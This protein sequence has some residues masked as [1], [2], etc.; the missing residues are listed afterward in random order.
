VLTKCKSGC[1]AIVSRRYNSEF[2]SHQ[3]LSL[4]A[5]AEIP[6]DSA[7]EKPDDLSSKGFIDLPILLI[8]ILINS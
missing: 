4:P 6:H 1:M 7:V 3:Y 8:K 5:L 2:S